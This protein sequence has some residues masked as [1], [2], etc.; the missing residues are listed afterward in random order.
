[1]D[2]IIDIL[3]PL[4]LEWHQIVI[5]NI[6]NGL[7]LTAVAF[8]VGVLLCSFLVKDVASGL[9]RELVK[10]KETLSVFESKYAELVKVQE[11]DT[12]QMAELQQSHDEIKTKLQATETKYSE[13]NVKEQKTSKNLIAKQLEYDDLE[14]LLNQKTQLLEKLQIKFDEQKIKLTDSVLEKM[15]F[16][17]VERNTER[18]A[19]E[20]SQLKQQLLRME[21]E[22]NDKNQLIEGGNKSEQ[23][24]RLYKDKIVALEAKVSQLKL[25]NIKISENNNNQNNVTDD[26]VKL[27]NKVEQYDKQLMMFNKKL[28]VLLTATVPETNIDNLIS[29]TKEEDGFMSKVLSLFASL[30]NATTGETGLEEEEIQPSTKNEGIWQ[31]H[32]DIIDQLTLQ[33]VAEKNEKEALVVVEASQGSVVNNVSEI[34]QKTSEKQGEKTENIDSFPQRLKGI[35]SRMIS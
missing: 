30:D 9:R 21:E 27:K 6:G 19:E 1:M 23:V 18:I 33:L 29:D 26:S 34:A 7:F 4:F 25:D 35:Y 17:E 11:H 28:Q 8:F 32:H 12:Q 5:E 15:K 10:E 22:L 20:S 3:A 2:K 24:A 31:K 13:L 16:E 14:L